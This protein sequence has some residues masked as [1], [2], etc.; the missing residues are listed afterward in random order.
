MKF[1]KEIINDKHG[2]WINP[3]GGYG[4]IL[5]LSGVLKQCFDKNPSMKYNLTRRTIYQNLLRGHPAI[6]KIGFPPRDV[7]IITTDYW[8]KEKIGIVSA[9]VHD[10]D[11]IILDEPQT[12]LDPKAR[13][14]VRNFILELRKMGKTIFFSSHL[15]Y[16]VSE[17]I[18]FNGRKVAVIAP[19]SD[20]PRKMMEPMIWHH[21]VEKLLKKKIFVIQVGR[22]NDI[23]IKGTYSL[24]GLTTPRQLISLLKKSDIIISVDNFIMHAAH[25]FK[26]P[27]IIIWGPTDSKVYGYTEQIHLQ[28]PYNDC[29][30]HDKCLGPNYPENYGTVCPFKNKHCMN[31]ISVDKIYNSVI[32]IFDSK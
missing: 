5:L 22:E 10:P 32:N 9:L 16:E 30:L 18:P 12:G 13:V 27:A 20:S 14:D 8:M 21:V 31:H 17:F 2:I 11:I 28:C 6:E 29:E 1:A 19:S 7:K 3:T 26:I 23:Y 25:L 15:L 4:D 24:L